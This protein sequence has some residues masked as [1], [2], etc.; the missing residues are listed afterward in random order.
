MAPPILSALLRSLLSGAKAFQNEASLTGGLFRVRGRAVRRNSQVHNLAGK[1]RH[2]LAR[3]SNCA[4][5]P[6]TGPPSYR[7]E[8]PPVSLL[9]SSMRT[10]TGPCRGLATDR[11]SCRP[12]AR[13]MTFTPGVFPST[14]Y[15]NTAALT[16][17]SRPRS[18]S[19][20]VFLMRIHET[21]VCLF[22]LGLSSVEQ[23]SS[24]DQANC[25]EKFSCEL[26]ARRHSDP[27]HAEAFELHRRLLS[28]RGRL[29]RAQRHLPFHEVRQVGT[30]TASTG[31]PF[32]GSSRAAPLSVGAYDDHQRRSD[33]TLPSL[34]RTTCLIARFN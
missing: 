32:V 15:Y 26:V 12:S 30:F 22:M 11:A 23:D 24:G 28:H 3:L 5:I 31:I 13:R 17:Y 9:L 10:S 8:R 34:T 18:R 7:E 16:Y 29:D 2:D 25:G 27:D 6:R 33:V 19:V 21:G 4:Q 1:H 14:C 20:G